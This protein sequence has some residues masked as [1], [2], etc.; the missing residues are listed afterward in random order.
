MTLKVMKNRGIIIKTGD[1]F[2]AF[3]SYFSFLIEEELETQKKKIAIKKIILSINDCMD[4]LKKGR[5]VVK[6]D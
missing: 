1:R 3:S 2:R 4:I 5:D 6:G